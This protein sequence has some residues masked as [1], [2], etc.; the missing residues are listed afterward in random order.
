MITSLQCPC[1]HNIITIDTAIEINEPVYVYKDM[2]VP[3]QLEITEIQIHDA[4]PATPNEREQWVIQQ[5]EIH[6]QEDTT[7]EFIEQVLIDEY[8]VCPDHLPGMIDLIK[9]AYGLYTPDGHELRI[10]K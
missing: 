8:H 9:Q 7:V 1:C 5:M 4:R 6:I 3:G 2:E 10:I